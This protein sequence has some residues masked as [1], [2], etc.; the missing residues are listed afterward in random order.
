MAELLLLLYKTNGEKSAVF[1]YSISL[2]N[3]NNI[4]TNQLTFPQK[5][6]WE[7]IMK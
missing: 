7:E 6:S 2:V 4:P 1:E 3:K 5:L